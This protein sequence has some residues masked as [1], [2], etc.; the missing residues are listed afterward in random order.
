M[1]LAIL[2]SSSMIELFSNKVIFEEFTPLPLMKE[3]TFFQILVFHQ[4][5]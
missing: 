5:F 4:G 2:S 3:F 1:I